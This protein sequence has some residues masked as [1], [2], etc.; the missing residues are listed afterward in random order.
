MR[1]VILAYLAG[2]IDGE[3]HVSI[4]MHRRRYGLYATARIAVGMTNP[5]PVYAL[6][7]TFGGTVKEKPPQG[8]S[9][10]KLYLWQISDH[11]A[12]HTA[13]LLLPYLTVKAPQAACI[14]A[15]AS[16][17]VEP[18]VRE[19]NWWTRPPEYRQREKALSETT[20]LFNQRGP[21]Q[22]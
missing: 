16:M 15:L 4:H 8:N 19:K 11:L 17:K 10:K 12:Y 2:I 20:K 7:Q 13:A 3:G 18:R 1:E 21:L 9:R 22:W 14:L 5:V 6:A